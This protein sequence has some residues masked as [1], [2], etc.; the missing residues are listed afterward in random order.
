MA[1]TE[2]IMGEFLLV[3]QDVR[4]T[5]KTAE[6]IL[7]TI[8]RNKYGLM[9]NVFD[10]EGFD[11][12]VFDENKQIF[13]R[14]ASPDIEPP[15]FIQVKCGKGNRRITNKKSKEMNKCVD[16]LLK[17]KFNNSFFLAIGR[18]Y[19]DIRKIDFYIIHPSRWDIFKTP[20][21]DYNFSKKKLDKAVEEG[22]IAKI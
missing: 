2:N 16:R 18:Y 12:I 11:L 3:N 22:K 1:N 19:E 13:K 14:V 21:N 10:S 17:G 20:S 5:G 9:S 6:Y 15:F 8:L 7:A 4:L